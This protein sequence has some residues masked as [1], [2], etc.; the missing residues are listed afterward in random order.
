MIEPGR[1]ERGV[2]IRI[3][4]NHL[5]AQRQTAVIGDAKKNRLQRPS[6]QR[7]AEQS[8]LSAESSTPAVTSAAC[9]RC[10]WAR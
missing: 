8:R 9:P 7:H 1:F 4:A 3:D 10:V 2:I 5:Q 6:S